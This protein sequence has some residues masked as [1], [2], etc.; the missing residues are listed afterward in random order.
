M[1][2]TVNLK[3]TGLNYSPNQLSVPEGSLTEAMNVVL[4]RDNVIESRR[5]LVLYGNSFGSV[6]D[7]LNQLFTY[8]NRILRQYNTTLQFDSD[9]QGTFESFAGS[10]SPVQPGLRMKSIESQGNFYFTTA[11]GIDK[12]SATNASQFSTASGYI[13]AAGG[14]KAIDFTAVPVADGIS[15]WLPQDST[16]AYREVWGTTDA[17]GLLILGTPSQP[18]AVYTPILSGL[19][20][21]Y[22]KLLE[23]L[24]NIAV[25]PTAA[26]FEYGQYV[27]N[28]S[29]PITASALTLGT[30]AVALATKIDNDIIYSNDTGVGTV[31]PLIISTIV[32]TTA[33]TVTITFSAGNPTQYFT[34]GGQDKIFLTGFG[35]G[36]TSGLSI[37]GAQTISSVTATT[38]VFNYVPGGL[39]VSETFTHA[40]CTIVSNQ[41]RSITQPPIPSTPPTDANLVALQTYIQNIILALQAEPSTV[42]SSNAQSTFITPLSIT[43]TFVVKLTTDIPQDVTSDYF[44]QIYR[45]NTLSA[46][47]TT[48][49]ANLVPND[50]M[51]LVYEAFPT[52]AEL[53]AHQ[54]IVTDITPDAFKGANLYTNAS[55]GEG[56]LQANDIPPLAH[57]INFFKNV[58]FYAN[59]STRQRIVP[60]S[61][62]GISNIANG[63]TITIA[64]TAGSNTYTFVTGIAQV[65]Y[66]TA[67]A[68]TANSL[69]GKYFNLYSANNA[70]SYYVW[71]KTSG[72]ST[73]DPAPAGKTGIK[74]YITTGDSA[75]N[76]AL[77]T[78]NAIAALGISDFTSTI[79][80]GAQFSVTNNVVGY[81]TSAGDPGSGGSGFTFVVHVSGVGQS[82]ALK[83]ILLSTAVS[84]AQQVTETSN[85]FIAVVNGNLNEVIYAF[86]TSS[87]TSVPGQM[88]LEGRELS[89]LPFYI[90]ASSVATGA[91]FSPTISPQVVISAAGAIS[92]ANPT[93][94]TSTAHGLI[95]NEQIIIT[96]SN[97][98]PS[99]DGVWSVTVLDANHFTIP[100]N[101]TATAGTSKLSYSTLG[102]AE[103][104]TNDVN[105]NRLYYSK[106]QQPE[107]VPIENFVDIGAKNKAILRIFPLRDTL[108]V[109]KEDGLFRL[110]GEVAPWF[111]SLFDS[112]CI[113]VAPDSVSIANNF[114]YAYTRQG[115]SVVTEAGVETISRPID[116]TI[117][118]ISTANYPA[119]STATWGLGYE[120]DNAYLLGTVSETTD[121]E[122]TIIYRY[123]NL[124][125]SWTNWDKSDTC[126]IINSA[127]NKLYMGAGDTNFIEVE[128]K[129]FTRLDYA[130]REID[131]AINNNS[132]SNNNIILTSIIGLAVGDAI[133]QD[134]LLT[135]YTF[136]SLLQKLDMDPTVAKVNISAISE[137]GTTVT[138]TT[139]GANNI[140]TLFPWV[141]IQNNTNCM[142]SINGIYIA[143]N[144]G[145]SG[146]NTFSITVPSPVTIMGTI[147]GQARLNY[148][149][150]LQ[151]LPGVNLRTSIVN[152][153]AKLDTDPNLTNG[154]YSSG[155]ASKS[156]SIT[157]I[158]VGFPA[159]V[160]ST[161]HGLENGR[162]ITITGSNSTPVINGNQIVTVSGANTFTVPITVN[163]AGTTGAWSTDDN[164]FVDIQAC[165]NFLVTNLN[166]DTGTSFKNYLITSGITEEEAIIIAINVNTKT[167]TTNVQ[168][169]WI[170]GPV[171]I[172][173]AITSTFT[174][175][176]HTLGDPL[177]YKHMSEATVMFE[178][179]AFTDATLSFATD[180]LP[181]LIDVD[182]PGDGNGIFGIGTGNFGNG[183]FG[184]N[185]HP[186]PFRTYIPRNAQR[187]RYMVVQFQHSIAREKYSIFG[188]SLTGN[189]G[190]S[191]RAYR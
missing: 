100:V 56:I 116:T 132:I 17:N 147:N 178:N 161:A 66:I 87:L 112:S 115:I 144:I 82:V 80:S 92:I 182:C 104:S 99:I 148:T 162:L 40:S 53:A 45:S 130:D 183:Y 5:G 6:T 35:V 76:V 78:S 120:S 185:S 134:Q 118:P 64:T 42:I 131:L 149:N 106:P 43:T 50:E 68:D 11:A 175:S 109:F 119:F 137:V 168:L 7:R 62:L 108:F 113:L 19:I 18:V 34:T 128:R 4:K 33:S 139:S 156:G 49:L 81:T 8:R 55:T 166:T 141:T 135:P 70:T 177:G 15:G 102:S 151:A 157:A 143:Q 84:P 127:D 145:G 73:S 160:T 180:L 21:D 159:S 167:I 88:L 63:D 142:P 129:T 89:T 176:P 41:F 123:S 60:F 191:T 75:A 57:D 155:I 12:I 37:N 187:C 164:S 9:G 105:P 36:S 174:Y 1:S 10:Y 170:V 16:V 29:V 171:I 133:V 125:K 13:T 20:P 30:Q 79:V 72:G 126:G 26:F 65:E 107:A 44:L 101:V 51:Q 138:I 38:A 136:N 28:Y 91:S 67:V 27:Q 98:T 52:S 14:I 46:T 59:T 23:G 3:A 189:I 71:Y 74:V 111:V 181:E 184:G 85:S 83:Q 77:K 165:Y 140:S 163:T 93:H 25:F 97:S 47:G 103:A 158:A 94:I 188:I 110:T 69:N 58:I 24:N 121:T 190:I 172:F 124:T 32:A 90:L 2:S 179:K 117:L 22:E 169:P 95:N 153:A 150:S 122:A 186:A 146:P 48:V 86:Y 114:I 173:K 96:G 154:N 152:L 54:M 31:G 39:T 61:L